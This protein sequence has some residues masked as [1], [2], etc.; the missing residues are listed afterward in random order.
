MKN[1]FVVGTSGS[2]KS[3]LG[4]FLADKLNYR[5]L[6]LDSIFW[7]PNWTKRDPE[8]LKTIILQEQSKPG[9]LVLDGNTLNKGAIISPGDVLIF[10]DYSRSLIVWRV[11]RRTIR[12]VIFR[13]ELWS[14]N[15][16]EVSF[17]FS[18]DPQLN[19]VLWAWTTHERRRREYL[20]L[21]ESLNGVTVYHVQTKQ[22]LKDLTSSF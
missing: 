16:E 6:E 15:R 4:R 7:L 19:P 5:Y 8:E 12:R 18:R 21:I 14:G 22:A 1:I 3:T 13:T 2:G 20:D 11:L 17:L 10:L 9:G